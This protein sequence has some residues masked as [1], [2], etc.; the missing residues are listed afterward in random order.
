MTVDEIEKIKTEKTLLSDEVMNEVFDE[1]NEVARTHLLI[2]LREK[3]MTL[4]CASKFDMIVNAWKKME[5]QIDKSRKE[6]QH[7]PPPNDNF[8]AFDYFED[9]HELACGAWVADQN[10]TQNYIN[11]DY[12]TK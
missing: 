7:Q 1:T 6:E 10:A 5:R 9:G 2:A 3:A 11:R 8:T 12:L 4:R